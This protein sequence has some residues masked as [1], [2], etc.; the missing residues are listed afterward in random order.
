[1]QGSA[2]RLK[3]P[4]KT[5]PSS[6]FASTS[7]GRW[8]KDLGP[9]EPARTGRGAAVGSGL[10]PAASCTLLRNPGSDV[11]HDAA[12]SS[13]RCEQSI[14]AAEG[15]KEGMRCE[16]RDD[17]GQLPCSPYLL[18]S[19]ETL[20]LHS[21]NVPLPKDNEITGH[22]LSATQIQGLCSGLLRE[23]RAHVL[24]LSNLRQDSTLSL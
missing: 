2:S 9:R 6:L 21:F 8:P 5:D 1:M 16:G 22:S 15:A 3:E 11:S 7:L 18:N 17:E 10:S 14:A 23:V 19:K 20:T 13:L 12:S 24:E 4:R